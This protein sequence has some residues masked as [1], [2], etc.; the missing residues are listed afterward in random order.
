MK[1]KYAIL[2]SLFLPA[3]LQ[4]QFAYDYLK[5]ADA[6]FRKHDYASAAGYYEKYLA[7]KT[8]R[9]GAS[10]NPY[11][12]QVK[13]AKRGKTA[14]STISQARWNLAESYRELHQAKK[15]AD[16]YSQIAADAAASFPLLQYHLSAQYRALGQYMEA[17]ETLQQFLQ[18]YT[19][20]DAY[21]TQAARELENLRFIQQQLSKPDLSLYQVS[22][23]PETVN[24]SGANYA[25]AFGPAGEAWFTSTRID[26]NW[27]GPRYSNRLYRGS[28]VDGLMTGITDAGILQDAGVQQG[29]ATF[30][31]DGKRA[32][33]TRWSNRN[34]KKVASIW[35]SVYGQSGWSNPIPAGPEVN[36]TLYSAQ[37]PFL[38][39]GGQQMMLS[40][41]RPGGSGGFDIWLAD[42]DREGLL[43]NLRN[44]GSSINTQ[45]DEQAPFVHAPSRSLVFSSN[46]RVGMGG[47]D[48]YLSTQQDAEWSIPVNLGYPVNSQRDDLYFVSRS[49]NR[50]ILSEVIFSSD[51]SADCCL[52]LYTLSK[53]RV[54]N[55]LKGTVVSCDKNL[56]LIGAS[57]TIEGRSVT[58]GSDGTY[59]FAFD[60]FTRVSITAKAIGYLDESITVAAP[61]EDVIQLKAPTICLKLVPPIFQS[62]GTIETLEDINFNFNKSALLPESKPYLDKLAEKLLGNPAAILEISGH[63]DEKGGDMYNQKLSEARARAVVDYLLTKG[64]KLEQLVAKGYGETVPLAPNHLDDGSDNPEGRRLNRRIAFKVLKQ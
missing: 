13:S 48:L 12:L 11:T 59:Q 38:L 32:W 2:I 31:V 6:F 40:A 35:L 34:G 55:Q 24:A 47:F 15:A 53:V 23:M 8:S 18:Q 28:F 56:P 63:T 14:V 22:K 45:G 29:A 43:F 50:Y 5:A 58:T 7:S 17:T 30:S 20:Q 41:D 10:Y 26:S 16:A 62:V 19:R 49:M 3:F 57:V 44:I 39:P 54:P 21:A 52:E 42:I 51:R 9:S 36:D 61:G 27:K 33:I 37:Q 64:V 1:R 60:E 25:I 46:G 4:A